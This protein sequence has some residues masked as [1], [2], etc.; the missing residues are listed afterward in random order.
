VATGGGQGDGWCYF[1][2][3]SADGRFV[4]FMSTSTNLVPGDTNG[5][6]DIFVRDRQMGATERVSVDSGGVQGNRD[7]T[8]QTISPDGRFVA[9]NSLATNLV[10]GDTNGTDDVFVHDRQAGTT[11]RASVDS[12]GVQGNSDSGWNGIPMSA[13]DRYVVFESYATN[14]VPADT[15]AADDIF[16]HDRGCSGSVSP[17]CVAKVNSLGCLPSIGSAGVPSQSGPDNFYVTASN[18]RNNKLGMLL[19]SL[20]SDNRPFFGGTLCVHNPIKRTPGQNSGGSPTGSD[21]T[22]AYSYH[23]TQNYMLQQLLGANTTVYAQFWSRD[24]GFAPPNN[25]GLTN[26]LQFTICP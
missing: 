13:D 18:V 9:F 8:V 3:I 20:A 17:Y 4:S 5:A 12:T 26:G 21:C 19:W 22:G 25:I 15:N 14:L 1:T 16:I 7:C 24:P 23:F 2:S 11:E 6:S 10:P